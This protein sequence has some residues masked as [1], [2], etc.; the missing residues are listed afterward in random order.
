VRLCLGEATA[1][2]LAVPVRR[3]GEVRQVREGLLRRGNPAVLL[4]VPVVR[5]AVADEV[6]GGDDRNGVGGPPLI[7]DVYHSP[8]TQLRFRRKCL[9]SRS[10]GD[11]QDG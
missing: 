8:A 5:R 6:A 9:Q 10:F 7:C 4:R 3:V 2:G 1:P 11:S